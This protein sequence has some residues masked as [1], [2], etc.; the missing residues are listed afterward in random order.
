MAQGSRA[1]TPQTEY[2]TDLQ[3]QPETVGNPHSL[4]F[5]LPPPCHHLIDPPPQAHFHLVLSASAWLS[6][7]SLDS[8][9]SYLWRL[10]SPKR[11]LHEPRPVQ[12]E[13]L[14][15]GEEILELLWFQTVGIILHFSSIYCVDGCW[16]LTA[17]FVKLSGVTQT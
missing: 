7:A 8:A 10:W 1:P 17:L 15:C 13:P 11:S 3:P 6:I 16:P 14:G 2:P 5:P 9:S 12:E 4:S